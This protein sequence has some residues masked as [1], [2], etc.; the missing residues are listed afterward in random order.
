MK[1][2]AAKEGFKIQVVSSYR[3][4]QHQ[5]RIWKRK[6]KEFTSE[7]LSPIQAIKKII[8][9]STIPGTSRHHWATDL[10]IVDGNARQ[11][12]DVL[13]AKNFEEKGAFYKFKV[14]LDANASTFGFYLVYTDSKERRGFKY[15]PWHIH[16]HP[17]QCLC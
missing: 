6:Y 15:E 2:E 1:T 14:W 13:L 7:G 17:Y 12:R 10:D 9:Y 3:N 16:M 5:N 4:Y 8:E 11:P